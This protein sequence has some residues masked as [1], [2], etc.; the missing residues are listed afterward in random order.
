MTDIKTRKYEYF[1][2]FYEWI[3]DKEDMRRLKREKMLA[4]KRQKQKH[5]IVS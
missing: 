4:K 2:A 3:V 1:E 5:L